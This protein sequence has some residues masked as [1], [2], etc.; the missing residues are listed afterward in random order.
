[1][2]LMD[3]LIYENAVDIGAFFKR[4]YPTLSD[5]DVREIEREAVRRMFAYLEGIRE[6]G[7]EPSELDV[8]Y[9]AGEEAMMHI[10]NE[11]YELTIH[12]RFYSLDRFIEIY[13]E[14]LIALTNEDDNF[15][16]YVVRQEVSHIERLYTQ[17]LESYEA[18]ED[19]FYFASLVCA[20]E[21]AVCIANRLDGYR[22]DFNEA[23]ATYGLL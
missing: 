14:E 6:N 22:S 5:M 13:I 10:E 16:A 12:R 4:D 18:G 15:L 19:A 8:L 3:D 7:R 20:R 11:L 1:M 23:R 17:T 21:A 2:A 9:G